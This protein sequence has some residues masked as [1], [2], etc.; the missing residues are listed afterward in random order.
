MPLAH[1]LTRESVLRHAARI[2]VTLPIVLPPSSRASSMLLAFGRQG[3]VGRFLAD[4][5]GLAIPFSTTAIV[6]AAAYMGLPFFVLSAEA[7]L[8]ALD[9]AA[10]SAPPPRSA[11]DRGGA[12]GT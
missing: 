2:V 11:R 7:G 10:A 3:L 1:W 4:W 9:G 12:A 8:R 6:V 5:F